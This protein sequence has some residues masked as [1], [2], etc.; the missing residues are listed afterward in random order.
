MCPYMEISLV[1]NVVSQGK[2]GNDCISVS[3]IDNK[4]AVSIK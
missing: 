3:R 2:Y 1:S 4:N